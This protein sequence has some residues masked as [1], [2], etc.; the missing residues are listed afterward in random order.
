MLWFDER[1]DYGFILTQEGERLHVDREG[2]V[3][4]A[5]VGRCAKLPVELTVAERD[6]QRTAVDV[7]FVAEEERRR[8]RRRSASTRSAWA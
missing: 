2:F 3:D 1:K 5:P 7:S 8:A 4:G 6:G